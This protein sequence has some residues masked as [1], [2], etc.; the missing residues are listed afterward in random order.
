LETRY[1]TQVVSASSENLMSLTNRGGLIKGLILVSRAAGVRTAITA[2]SNLGVLLDNQPINEGVP[3][4]EHYDVHRRMSGYFGADA[5]TSY[6]PL[7]SGVNSG[8]DRGVV[9][10]NFSAL[11]SAKRDTWLNTRNGSLFQVKVTPGAAATTMEVVTQL[12]QVKD[13]AAFYDK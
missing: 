5:T 13:A 8:L 7:A 1:E 9:P 6:A 3:I 12:A 10:I 2:A 4:E 11:S